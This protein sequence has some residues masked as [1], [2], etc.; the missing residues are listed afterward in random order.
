[1]D[2]T[3]ETAP[4]A[5]RRQLHLM[6]DAYRADRAHPIPVPPMTEKQLYDA[7]VHLNTAD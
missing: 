4:D 1:M 5:W 3:S 7:M 2:A 6:L